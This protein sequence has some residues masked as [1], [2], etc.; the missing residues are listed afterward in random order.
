MTGYIHGGNLDLFDFPTQ[1]NNTSIYW[2]HRFWQ[3]KTS[4]KKFHRILGQQISSIRQSKKQPSKGHGYEVKPLQF[5]WQFKD[6]SWKWKLFFMSFTHIAWQKLRFF[7]LFFQFMADFWPQA[8]LEFIYRWE[9]VSCLSIQTAY[10]E[11][12]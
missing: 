11:V 9:N 8:N 6:S 10:D 5:I 12:Y 1:T 4:H 3:L 7:S 2:L